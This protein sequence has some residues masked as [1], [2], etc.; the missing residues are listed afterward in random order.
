MKKLTKIL[1]LTVIFALTICVSSY[2]TDDGVDTNNISLTDSTS[3]VKLDA[4]EGVIPSD[5]TLI[6]ESIIEPETLDMVKSIIGDT[7]FSAYHLSLTSND[8]DVELTNT[9]KISLPISSEYDKTNL[10][11]YKINE[12]NS[13]TDFTV[14]VEEDFATFNTESLGMYVLSEIVKDDVTP[15]TKPDDTTVISLTD[16][17]F[18]IKLSANFGIIPD[19]TT[20]NIVSLTTGERF[21][22]IKTVLGDVKFNAFDICLMSNGNTIQPTGNVKLSIPIPADFNKDNLI[23]YRIDADNT[24]VEYP[25]QIESNFA[26]FETN[27]FSDYVL[28]EKTTNT[29]TSSDVNTDINADSSIDTAADSDATSDTNKLDNEPKTGF[30]NPVS[31]VVTVLVIACLGLAFCIKKISK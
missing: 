21:D 17:V 6:V 5:S 3:N 4:A 7:N 27:H 22:S 12:D 23:V 30:D 24:K 16:D 13:K 26:V 25:V 10:I 31:F 18:N 11:V 20:L 29:D 14:T 1:F 19:D 2:A 9:V 15:D 28:A 8:T